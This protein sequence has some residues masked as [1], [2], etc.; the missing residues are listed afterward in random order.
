MKRLKRNSLILTIPLLFLISCSKEWLEPDPLSFLTPENVYVNEAGFEAI[1]VTLR[2][3][4]QYESTG[5]R[6]PLSMEFA[7]SDLAIPLVQADFRRTTPSSS[8]F[9]PFLRYFTNVYVFIKNANVLISRIDDI[10][11]KDEKVK[12]RLLAE[13][14]W[15]RAYWYYR[16]VH[17][18]GDVPWIGE[19]LSG[20]KL[21]FQTHSRWAILKKIQTDLEFAAQWLPVKP[22]SLG[23]VTKGA[24]NHLLTKVYLANT[25][26]DKAIAAATSVIDGPY[27]LM[28]TRFGVDASDGSRNVMW[29]LHRYQNKN[30]PQNTET[31]YTTIDRP[32]APPSSWSAG[33]FSMRWYTPSYWKILDG[34]GNRACN[35]NTPTGD[36]LGIGNGDVRTN[37]FFHYRIWE[38]A[39]HKWQQTP[40]LRRAGNN[41]IEM[42]DEIAEILNCRAASPQFRQ[43]LTKK[44]YGSLV[45]TTDTWF[46][47]PHYKT[48]VPSDNLTQPLGGQGDWYI[49]RL[50]ETY[51]LRA[52]AYYW[53]GQTGPA[54]ADIN[55]VRQRAKAPL[56]SAADVTIDYI[57]DERARELYTE[58]PRHSE[59]VRVSYILAKL[60]TSGYSLAGFSQKNWYY[61]RVKRLNSH[62]RPPLFQWFGNTAAM[63]PY[64]VLWPIPQS[65]IT[66]NTLGTVNQNAGYVGAEG[67]VPPLETIE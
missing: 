64:H 46:P 52:E 15:H 50:A 13:A 38:D 19:E 44:F 59:M 27:A 18:Y 16:L 54:A 26:F 17:S 53:K 49:F 8:A 14:Y 10:E 30:N 24:A 33:T 22:A 6:H 25:E 67:N 62:Y 45:D 63:D 35:W 3:N 7:T 36:T 34:T 43:P 1:L 48:Y 39:T 58:E 12:N 42:G 23:N 51:L 66:A 9:F 11:W 28:T 2:K 32:D 41:W 5:D 37:D 55:K 56:I 20:A 47:W 4:L 57:F 65:V 60:N 61:D 40:D 21:D 29:D 31:I